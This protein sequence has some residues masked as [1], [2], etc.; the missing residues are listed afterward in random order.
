MALKF[1]KAEVRRIKA[2][3]RFDACKKRLRTNEPRPES[4]RR[5]LTFVEKDD[6]S[7]QAYMAFFVEGACRLPMYGSLEVDGTFAE[8]VEMMTMIGHTVFWPGLI[9]IFNLV[10]CDLNFHF[11]CASSF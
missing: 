2:A 3:C 5:E 9:A 10:F 11:A 1:A 4:P 8:F 6:G 7:T